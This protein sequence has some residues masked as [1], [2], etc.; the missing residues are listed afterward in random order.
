MAKLLNKG[1]KSELTNRKK[2][3]R[4][5]DIQSGIQQQAKPFSTFNRPGIG[6]CP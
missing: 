4:V 2:M 3:E 6:N 5:M 1:L